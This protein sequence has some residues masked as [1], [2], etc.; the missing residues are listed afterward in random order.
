MIAIDNAVELMMQT[1]IGL[2]KRITGIDI[3]RKQREE[4]SGTFPSLLDGIEKHAAERIV[5][6]NLGEIEWYHRLR[7]QLYHEGNGLTVERQKVEL[8]AE[9]AA[10]LFSSLFGE[11]LHLR[12]TGSMVQFGN[13]LDAWV[14]IEKAIA[15]NSRQAIPIV[16]ARTMSEL[17]ESGKL[18]TEDVKTLQSLRRI[19]NQVVH[20][21]ADPVEVL[22]AEVVDSANKLSRKL[23]GED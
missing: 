21:M 9:L 19:R 6:L 22:S 11:K 23:S 20:G 8:Y 14:A 18:S 5:G 4:I 16:D 17:V 7:N 12:P 3:T 10:A 1:F 2:P 15:R 13:F